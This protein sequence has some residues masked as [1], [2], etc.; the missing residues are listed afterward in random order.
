MNSLTERGCKLLSE[1]GPSFRI[2]LFPGAKAAA[3]LPQLGSRPSG[4][5]P[6]GGR[7]ASQARR[8]D[9]VVVKK[10]HTLALGPSSRAQIQS[11]QRNRT[12][13][14]GRNPAQPSLCAIPVLCSAW[15]LVLGLVIGSFC[16]NDRTAPPAGGSQRQARIRWIDQH[17]LAPR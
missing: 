4:G 3:T 17:L 1:K 5:E 14:S 10:S 7:A 8:H 12:V 16:I 6:P 9:S 11:G 13:A 15:L 2:G